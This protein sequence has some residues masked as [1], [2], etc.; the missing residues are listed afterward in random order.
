MVMKGLGACAVLLGLVLLIFA[1]MA[2][3]ELRDAATSETVPSVDSLPL[4]KIVGP[5][6]FNPGNA[7]TKPAALART[8][9]NRIYAIG[10]GGIVLAIAG[11]LILAI[12]QAR[13]STHDASS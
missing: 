12:P 1:G 4:T 9:F 2:Y 6:L 11:V 13:G 7:G 3:W 5:E 10:G 8:T